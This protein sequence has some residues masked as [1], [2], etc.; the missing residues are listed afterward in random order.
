MHVATSPAERLFNLATR[1]HRGW[2]ADVAGAFRRDSWPHAPRGER[3]GWG[4]GVVCA[5]IIACA[6]V[7]P[8]PV[9][10]QVLWRGLNLGASP[11]TVSQ[12]FPDAQPPAASVTLA[13]GETDQLVT[14]SFF[15][16]DR[17][18]EVRFF[19][20]EGGLT[21]VMLTPAA[22]D[23]SRPVLN[24][25]AA[26]AMAAQLTQQ[27]GQPFDCG[28]KSFARVDLYECKWLAKPIVIRL[29]YLDALGQSP[30][31]RIVFRKADDAAYDF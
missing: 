8:D 1:A 20:R 16:A 10:A 31:L 14:H 4:R 29:W 30:S 7:R 5:L 13:D 21:A 9:A 2:L 12:A 27:Y 26:S 22:I 3:Q 23:P 11:K 6:F 17:F 19:F 15:V 25:R 24:I 28:D 18:M